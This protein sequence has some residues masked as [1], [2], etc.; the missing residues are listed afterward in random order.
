MLNR[1]AFFCGYKLRQ[2]PV[3][4]FSLFTIDD[5]KA[6]AVGGLLSV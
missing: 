6:Q 4:L 3:W 1:R 2:T 5:L